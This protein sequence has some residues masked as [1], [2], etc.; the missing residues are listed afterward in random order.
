MKHPYRYDR[1]ENSL[2]SALSITDESRTQ[3]SQAAETDINLIV[4]RFGVTGM[5]PQV[6]LPPLDMDFDEA[7]YSYRDAMDLVNAADRA[8]KQLSADVRKRFGN[9]PAEFVAFCS[10]EENL[11]E[12]RKMGLAIEAVVPPV[13]SESSVP[14]NG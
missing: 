6:Q 13:S 4:K 9:D 2:E 7:V 14:A 11:P 1:D 3:Q 5:L 8:F 12:M 10:K